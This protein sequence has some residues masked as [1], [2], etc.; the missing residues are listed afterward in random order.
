LRI[1]P[2]YFPKEPV[3]PMRVTPRTAEEAKRVSSRELIKPGWVTS[4]ID[5]AG[6]TKSRFG[7]WMIALRHLVQMPDR[8]QRDLPDWLLDVPAVAEKLRS[9]VVAVDALDR[10]EQ[11]EISAEDFVGHT[12]QILVGIEKRRGQPDRN[13]VLQYR[14]AAAEVVNLHRAAE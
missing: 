11:G 6:E 2:A 8:S 1:I 4:I 3:M 9:A 7:N 14:A 10:Y 12:V 13:C 5:Q